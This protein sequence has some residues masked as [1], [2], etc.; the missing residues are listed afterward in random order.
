MNWKMGTI[1]PPLSHEVFVWESGAHKCLIWKI[2]LFV[3]AWYGQY[4]LHYHFYLP[5][6]AEMALYVINT[7]FA[8][9]PSFY[10][11]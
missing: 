5:I 3:I 11:P 10:L 7:V 9:I 4:P 1:F 6:F 8:L 2:H